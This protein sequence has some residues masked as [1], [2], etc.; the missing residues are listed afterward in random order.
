MEHRELRVLFDYLHEGTQVA[1]TKA[2]PTPRTVSGE[3]EKNEKA[4]LVWV[5]VRS[6]VT[7][8]G[9]E[10]ALKQIVPVIDGKLFDA[11]VSLS[12]IRATVMA[13]PRQ[14]IWGAKLYS[15]GKPMSVDPFQSTTLK[16]SE[17]ITIETLA[18]ATDITQDYRITGYGYVYKDHELA[19]D[20]GIVDFRGNPIRDLARGRVLSIDKDPIAVTPDNWATLP[21]G[22]D[23]AI[24]KINPFIRYA[25]NASDTDG[26]SGDYQFRY[27]TQDVAERTEEMYF[28]F[29]IKDALLV[30]G[31]G[32]KAPANL[33]YTSL[34]IAGD[35]HPKDKFPT[36]QYNNPLNFGHGYPLWPVDI[37]IYYAIPRLERPYLIWNEKGIVVV[38]DDGTAITTGNIVAALTGIRIEMKG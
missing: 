10:E 36:R 21:G 25:Y 18:G 27:D 2:T 29:G 11:Y 12:G 24:P 8:A 16:Y 19:R 9:V 15:F 17:H 7:G 5:G 31:L 23:Q 28:D 35:Y 32:V 38:N 14:H 37:P 13:P 6:P 22:K 20:F 34:L 4:E 3:L 33:E 26:K 30:E 1:N